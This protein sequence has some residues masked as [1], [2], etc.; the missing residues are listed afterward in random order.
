[1]SEL[2]WMVK[3]WG[4]HAVVYSTASW[5]V[6]LLDVRAGEQLSVQKHKHRAERWTVLSGRC[7]VA[8][9]DGLLDA[10]HDYQ[11]LGADGRL[12]IPAGWT[13]TLKAVEDTLV[14]EVVE[15]RYDEF[16]IVRLVDRYGR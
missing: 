7:E 5:T 9:W 2:T 15:G 3:P 1:M 11:T 4:R 12:L 14:L 6:K 13:H 16:D 10:P 8:A